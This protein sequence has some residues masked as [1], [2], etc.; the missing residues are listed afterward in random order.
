MCIRDRF[1]MFAALL[2]LTIAGIGVFPLWCVSGYAI[3]AI[4][5]TAIWRQLVTKQGSALNAVLKRTAQLMLAICLYFL[6]LAAIF[7]V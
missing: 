7:G 1:F 6:V 2:L 5:G 4:A 3:A